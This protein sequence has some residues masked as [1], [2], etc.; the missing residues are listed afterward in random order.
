MAETT[1]FMLLYGDYPALHLKTLNSFLA[2]VPKDVEKRLWLNAVCLDTFAW[3]LN[4]LPPNTILYVNDENRP[5]YKAMQLLFYDPRHPITTPWVTWMDDDIL[6]TKPDW[7]EKTTEFISSHSNQNVCFFGQQRRKGHQPGVRKF[8]RQ[9]KW[10]RGRKFQ[11]IKGEGSS[12]FRG[13]GIVFIQGSYWWL[14]TDALKKLLW[15]DER[16]SHNGGDTLLSEAVWQQK[17]PQHEFFYGVIPNNA[18]RRGI[19]ENPAGF[20]FKRVTK[21]DKK[22][23]TMTGQIA[24]YKGVLAKLKLGLIQQDPHT[25]IVGS[26][27]SAKSVK[28]PPKAD[29]KPRTN[30]EVIETRQRR[31]QK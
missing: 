11:R 9:A 21:T 20:A 4:N 14:R 22:P 24:R 28:I 1:A 23:A 16:L 5:K 18:D 25:I 17:L 19:S 6:I 10:F 12:S 31:G 29:D 30:K 27:V 26:G 13:P 3:L 8:I 15:P 2:R 7:Y